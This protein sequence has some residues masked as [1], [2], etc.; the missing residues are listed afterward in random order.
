MT[1]HPWRSSGTEDMVNILETDNRGLHSAPVSF[2]LVTLGEVF[3]VSKLFSHVFIF[4]NYYQCFVEA[5]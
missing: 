2:S 5:V 4:P 3:K 1:H